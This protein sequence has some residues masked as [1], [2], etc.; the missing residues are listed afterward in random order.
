MASDKI[1]LMIELKNKK[2]AQEEKKKV[3]Q[4]K[5]PLEKF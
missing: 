4:E 1:D 2:Q 3:V 5:K